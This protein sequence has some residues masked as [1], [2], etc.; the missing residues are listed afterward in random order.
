MNYVQKPVSL[1]QFYCNCIA[2]YTQS[3]LHIYITLKQKDNE[4]TI[5]EFQKLICNSPIFS[6]VREQQNFDYYIIEKL[7]IPSLFDHLS[8]GM[9]KKD[10]L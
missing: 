2:G 4:F 10:F 6:L 5:L 9:R 7:F 3:L 1:K 8:N